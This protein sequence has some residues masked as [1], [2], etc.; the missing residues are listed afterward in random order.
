MHLQTSLSTKDDP[1]R[2]A[3]HFL[4]HYRSLGVKNFHFFLNINSGNSERDQDYINF[5]NQPDIKVAEIFE[6]LEN[7]I[8]RT[9]MYHD[10]RLKKL[11]NEKYVIS[12]DI[13]EFLEDPKAYIKA[14]IH[15]DYDFIPGMLVDRFGIDGFTHE[16]KEDESLFQTFPIESDFT[17]FSIG[18]MM[19]KIPI[20]KPGIKHTTGFHRIVDIERH[21]HPH[22]YVRVHHFKWFKDVISKI[23]DRVDRKWGGEKYL[24]ECNYFLE[25][26]VLGEQ[27]IS[28]KDC[29]SFLSTFKNESKH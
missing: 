5:L 3:N 29:T 1:L 11:M 13:D 12:I 27:Q 2:L 18:G 15:H 19:Q 21:T 25:N 17:Y 23:Q 7:V 20:L 6:G 16:I 14:A 28:L 26:Y 9:T 8:E 10:Y 4:N 24:Q 22:W